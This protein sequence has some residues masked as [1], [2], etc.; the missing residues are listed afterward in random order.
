MEFQ[1]N[2]ITHLSNALSHYYGNN[3]NYST[4]YLNTTVAP[5]LKKLQLGKCINIKTIEGNIFGYVHDITYP[6]IT[7]NYQYDNLTLIHI[8]TINPHL[9]DSIFY[10]PIDYFITLQELVE[11]E[12]ITI[13]DTAI[14]WKKFD[15]PDKSYI[16]TN[17]C[18]IGHPIYMEFL[19]QA[20]QIGEIRYF[21]VGGRKNMCILLPS[22]LSESTLLS[23][24]K[25]IY[26]GNKVMEGLI[27]RD[28]KRLTTVWQDEN[29]M[30]PILKIEPTTGGYNLFIAS[31]IARNQEIIDYPLKQKLKNKKGFSNGFE[32][33]MLP[34]KEI[35]YIL[36]L[37]EARDVVWFIN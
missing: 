2:H 20:Y 9:H 6:S 27:T 7:K 14:D 30:K 10:A 28:I 33:Y 34:Y 22:G 11:S 23:L 17:Y 32:I 35:R 37:L 8:K 3:S 15:R 18:L 36:L 24:K 13:Y 12:N 16:R 25:P 29:V 4:T 21:D 1:Q 26:Q 31:E 19:R 5:L